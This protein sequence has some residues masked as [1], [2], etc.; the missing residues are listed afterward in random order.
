MRASIKRWLTDSSN[1]GAATYPDSPYAQDVLR[2]NLEMHALTQ[3]PSPPG[4]SPWMVDKQER[5]PMLMFTSP[6]GATRSAISEDVPIIPIPKLASLLD[7]QYGYIQV[8]RLKMSSDEHRTLLNAAWSFPEQRRLF[9][10]FP[11][12][13]TT[14]ACAKTNSSLLPLQQFAG[15]DANNQNILPAQAFLQNETT[16]SFVWWFTIA[17]PFLLLLSTLRLIHVICMDGCL[18][19]WAALRIAKG[20]GLYHS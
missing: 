14:D 8:A 9:T 6:K 2:A 7:T 18:Q 15:M 19:A 17:L 11:C 5:P 3:L 13:A 1:G 20:R 12:F 10:L 4:K 16:R